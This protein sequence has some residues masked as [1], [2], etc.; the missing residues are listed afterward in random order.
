[1]HGRLSGKNF[2]VIILERIHQDLSTSKFSYV[3]KII[4]NYNYRLHEQY[5]MLKNHHLCI[6]VVTTSA[7]KEKK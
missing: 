1:M 4:V 6:P 7:F 5:M 3:N 2:V